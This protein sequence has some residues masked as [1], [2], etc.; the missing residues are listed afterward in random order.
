M[1]VASSS[2]VASIVAPLPVF[3]ANSFLDDCR[4]CLAPDALLAINMLARYEPVLEGAS[5]ID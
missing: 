5:A 1:D 3:L 4:A 2:H